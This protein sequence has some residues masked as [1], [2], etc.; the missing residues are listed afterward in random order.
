MNKLNRLARDIMLA[1][2]I[3][4]TILVI[5]AAI[6][7]GAFDYFETKANQRAHMYCLRYGEE[8]LTLVEVGSIHGALCSNGRETFWT[9]PIYSGQAE[10]VELP[11]P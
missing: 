8:W 11:R 4:I 2:R 6:L 1:A 7:L 3:Y 9:P 5:L 10:I